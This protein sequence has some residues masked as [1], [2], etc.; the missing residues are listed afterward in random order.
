MTLLQK[1]IAF[2]KLYRY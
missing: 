2:L 1:S